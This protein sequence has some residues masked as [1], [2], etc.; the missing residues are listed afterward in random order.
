VDL[1][2]GHSR[3]KFYL[4]IALLALAIAGLACQI[5]V[6]GPDAP[7]APIPTLEGAQVQ[8]STTWN[9]ALEAALTTGQVYVI[10]DES[11][12]TTFLAAKMA[13][14]EEPALLAPQ[15]YLQ[16]DTLQIFG[17]FDQG[18]FLAN[19]LLIVKPSID[20][21]G[22]ISFELTQ[23]DIGPLPIPGAL[24]DTISAI[25]TEAFTG[26]IGSLATGIRITSIAI[27][28]G[29]MAIVGELR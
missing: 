7:G 12:L 28:D 17:I 22:Q 26:T 23:A 19:A 15:V 6:G 29:E 1:L 16:H 21:E 5:E 24:K 20:A 14:S 2:I 4:L 8:L 27:A 9:Q 25:L 18:P 3:R 13:E 11:Q 10:L